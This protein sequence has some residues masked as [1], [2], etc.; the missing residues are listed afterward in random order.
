MNNLDA[1][2]FKE[3]LMYGGEVLKQQQEEINALNVFPVP[4]GDTGSNMNMTYQSGMQTLKITD[5]KDISKLAQAFS[6]GLLMGARGNSGVILSQFFR[7]VSKGL[8]NFE[9]VSIKQ[10]H[11]AL[12]NGVK[13]A[14]ASVI[15]AVEGTILTVANQMVKNTSDNHQ[16]WIEYFKE[17]SKNANQALEDTPNLLPILK[18]ANVVDS[19]GAG[20]EY[21][22][23]GMLSNLMGEKIEVKENFEI[24]RQTEVHPIDPKEI[25]YGFCTEMLIELKHPD[26]VELADVTKFLNNNGDSVVA[27]IDENILKTHVHTEN[28]NKI[29]EY[30]AKLGSYINIKSENMRIQ[31]IEAQKQKQAEIKEVGIVAVASSKKMA[32][33]FKTIQNVEIISGGQSLNPSI[34]DV[35]NAIRQANAKNVIILP[36]N[37]N[38]I[39]AAEAASKLFDDVKIEIIKT[40]HMTQAVEALINF[41]AELTFK[42]NVKV[43]K[44]SLGGLVNFE[45]TKSIKD[46]SMNEINIKKDDFIVINDGKIIG[47]NIDEKKILLKLAYY[48]I[49]QDYEL[50]TVLK[51]EDANYEILNEFKE[52]LEEKLPFVEISE[53]Q[54]EQPIYCYLISA[55]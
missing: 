48:F 4:D 12:E 1:K 26:K 52:Y 24:F 34:E 16:E 29:F 7:G 14:Y 43:M 33:L 40:K 41:S 6:K 45:I 15:K 18:E 23:R 5:D 55:L 44:E 19:G 2:T 11:Q 13:A 9:E 37:S 27:I 25:Q 21:I 39:M 10:F 42:E 32:E 54:T 3:M 8:A 30:G 47:A 46:T 31:A 22:F 49:E 38:I 53:Y 17:L 28:P 20:F 50:I 51:G 36:N 35:S